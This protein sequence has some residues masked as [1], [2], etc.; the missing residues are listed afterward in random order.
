MGTCDWTLN[1]PNSGLED[2]LKSFTKLRSGISL[3]GI[4]RMA[5]LP[6]E[7]FWS[8]DLHRHVYPIVMSRIFTLLYIHSGL[9]PG[10]SIQPTIATS[11]C[12]P[13]HREQ[14][15]LSSHQ[16]MQPCVLLGFLP[17]LSTWLFLEPRNE[18]IP[19]S[20]P[21]WCAG[22]SLCTKRIRC[23]LVCINI[24][25]FVFFLLFSSD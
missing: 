22:Y 9:P 2:V 4:S 16:R 21:F 15:L 13:Y 10:S 11:S 8:R 1:G 23:R 20:R 24:D 25:G 17:S 7:S 3:F 5:T 14:I 6:A 19:S 12:S 18:R